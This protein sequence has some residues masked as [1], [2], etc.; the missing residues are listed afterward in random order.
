MVIG[1]LFW[2]NSTN[3]NTHLGDIIIDNM[4]KNGV[5]PSGGV[6]C[7]QRQQHNRGCSRRSRQNTK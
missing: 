4:A 2:F 1:T 6:G 7:L 5:V 3:T